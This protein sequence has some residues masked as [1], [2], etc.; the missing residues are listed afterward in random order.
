MIID[1]VYSFDVVGDVIE[2]DYCNELQ[3]MALCINP[4]S[5][6]PRVAKWH[7]RVNE[8]VVEISIYRMGLAR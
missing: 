4:K 1:T 5:H 6:A 8:F 7:Y 2:G 3:G